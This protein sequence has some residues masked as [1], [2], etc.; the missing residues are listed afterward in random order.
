MSRR[1]RRNWNNTHAPRAFNP[2]AADKIEQLALIVELKFNGHCPKCQAAASRLWLADRE[3][4]L[5]PVPYFHVGY[6]LPSKLR[7]IAYQNKRVGYDLLVKAAA[8]TTLAIAANP[9]RLGARIVVTAVL[10]T[11]GYPHVHMIVP[12][13]GSRSTDRGGSP[14][15]PTSSCTS[16]YWRVYSAARC[17]HALRCVRRRP[18]EVVQRACVDAP[19]NARVFWTSL[20]HAIRCSH[21]SDLLKAALHMPPGLYGDTRI[22]SKSLR[23]ALGSMRVSGFPDPVSMTVVPY[24]SLA[25]SHPRRNS[26]DDCQ[27]KPLPELGSFPSWSSSPKR[28]SPSCWPK[29][30]PPACGAFALACERATNPRGLLF[31]PPIGQRPLRRRSKAFGCRADPFWMF[32]QEFACLPLSSGGASSPSTRRSPAHSGSFPSEE[33]TPGSPSRRWAQCPACSSSVQHSYPPLRGL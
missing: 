17:C 28:P 26:A 20:K 2:D 22:S 27:L 24:L 25:L 29:T 33:Q 19:G 10:H 8:E 7:D 16:T 23:R 4:E 31:A 21:V 5:L 12:V 3:A 18:V 11:W 9:R 13:A 15:A 32:F 6:T 1:Q 30:S 14:P